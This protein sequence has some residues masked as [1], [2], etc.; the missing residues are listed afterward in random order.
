M[1]A[2]SRAGM[3]PG[4]GLGM[5]RVGKIPDD[6]P[7]IEFGAFRLGAEEHVK[8]ALL[9]MGNANAIGHLKLD[10]ADAFFAAR[11]RDEAQQLGPSRI[12]DIQNGDTVYGPVRGVEI[13]A[14]ATSWRA[15]W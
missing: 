9:H 5:C 4:Y 10:H 11:L 14:P 8:L 15:I 2:P 7:L 12:G 3:P 1:R 13:E 6:D